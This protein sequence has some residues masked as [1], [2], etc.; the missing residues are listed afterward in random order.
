MSKAAAI[1]SILALSLPA[2]AEPVPDIGPAMIGYSVPMNLDSGPVRSTGTMPEV[3]YSAL[4]TEPNAQWLRVQFGQVDFAGLKSEGTGAYLRITSMLD[5]AHQYLDAE[6]IQHWEHTSAY[7]NGDTVLVELI[8]HPGTGPSRALITGALAGEPAVWNPE[9]ICGPSDD[10]KL[11]KDPRSART[12]GGCSAWVFD[13]GGINKAMSSA[14][15]CGITGSSVIF[16]NVPLSN[17]NGTIVNPPPK[18]Q[19]VVDPASITKNAGNNA[20]GND[21]V[22]FG[23]FANSTTGLTAFQAQGAYYS[24]VESVPALGTNVRIT[25]YGTTSSP[26][27]PTWNQVQKTHVGKLNGG[28]TNPQYNP[29]TTGGNSGSPIINDDSGEVFGV[30]GYGGCNSGGGNNSGTSISVTAYKNA[31]NTPKG[32]FTVSLASNCYADFDNSEALSIDD[33]IAFQTAFAIGDVSA[34]CDG[35]VALTD[36]VNFVWTPSLTIDDFIC[37]QTS[38]AIGC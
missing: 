33:F 3:V 30:H 6:T 36:P 12:S 22:T 1:L 15:H 8:A 37:F 25:G 26:I 14:G 24:I 7:F 16:F 20:P 21:W 28:G 18:D 38:F 29:D 31:V 34:N 9:S 5:Q 35:S 27:S 11:S 10:R 17:P 13:R 4:I 32:V 23:V 19:Y 2:Q